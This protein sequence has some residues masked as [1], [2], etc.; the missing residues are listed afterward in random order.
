MRQDTAVVEGEDATG[1]HRSAMN[2]YLLNSEGQIAWSEKGRPKWKRVLRILL[3]F[4]RGQTIDQESDD[5]LLN[6]S[7][8]ADQYC[9]KK[10]SFVQVRLH[11]P[12][13]QSAVLSSVLDTCSHLAQ[14]HVPIRP[15]DA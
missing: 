15:N 12:L 7:Q 2:N 1:I 6:L 3:P 5:S 11:S 4:A 9:H 14:S 10:N 8:Q 13:L